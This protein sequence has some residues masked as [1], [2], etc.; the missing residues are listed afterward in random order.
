MR[1]L[2]AIRQSKTRDRAISPHAQREAITAW[3][4][5]KGHEPPIF[6]ED[7]STSGSVSPFERPFLGPYLTDPLKM[8]LW[9]ILVTTKLDRACRSAADYLSLRTWCSEMGKSYVSLAEALDDTTA[10][11]RAM[12]T[13]IAA[14]AEFERE[15]AS[16]RRLETLAALR[17]QGRWPGGRPPFGWRPD[18]RDD[19]YY[20]VPD[21]GGMAD[22]LRSMADDAIDG[23]S[24]QQ[25]AN[26]LNGREVPNRS[27]KSWQPESVRL[28]LRSEPTMELLG[29]DKA[30]E[31]RAAL[32]AKKK[33]TGQWESGKH[34]LLRVLYC[35][36]CQIPIY[37]K[38]RPNRAPRYECRKCS[39][40]VVKSVIEPK[41]E[42]ELRG[43]WGDRPHMIH[44][45]TAGDNH[46][47]EIRRLENQ[48]AMAQ[49]IELI[50]TSMLEAK[51]TELKNAPHDAPKV[52]FIPSGLTIAQFWD[53][54]KTPNERGKFL[55]DHGVKVYAGRGGLFLME[56]TWLAAAAD[57]K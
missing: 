35:I 26:W 12:S 30:G 7:L 48:L 45:V 13:V 46:A 28:I 47:R 11:G 18:K 33:G 9:D 4:L 31:L 49:Q 14:F 54:L 57:W 43:R 29:D 51:I 6:T 19:G 38:C 40:T 23:V 17:V 10:A 36:H 21:E 25:I 53:S 15:R 2:G 3:A 42:E 24:Y 22:V 39:Y 55:R 16:E 20:L 52:D 56:P 44:K 50:D 32:E 5:A 34:M 1:V 37:G 41:V 8:G 27:G